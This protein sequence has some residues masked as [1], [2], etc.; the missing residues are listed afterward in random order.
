MERTTTKKIF[1]TIIALLLS[2][3]LLFSCKDN[4]SQVVG[5]EETGNNDNTQLLT[6]AIS[7]QVTN[8]LTGS[9]LEDVSVLL[10]TDTDVQELT[11]DTQGK[12]STEIQLSANINII[13]V[14]SKTG[15]ITDSTSAYVI[16]GKDK[17]VQRLELIPNNTG[18]VPS[19]DPVSIFMQ[20]QSSE[21]IGVKESGSEETARIIFIVQDSAGTPIDL[22]HTVDV[23]FKF[24]AQPGGGEE[25]SPTSVKTNN[26]GE[27]IVNLTAGTKAGTVQ[28]IAEIQLA[29]KKITS[30]P[31]GISIHG[32]LPDDTHFSIAPAVVNF[33][34][35][36]R[37]GLIDIIT[38]YVGD[39]YAN[40]VRPNT[41]VYFTSTGGIID[42]STQTDELGIGSVNLISS[43]PQPVHPIFGAGFA[44]ITA[45]TAD[46]NSNTIT[47]QIVVL[48]SGLPTI[49]VSPNSINIPNLGSQSFSY[50][51]QDQNGNPL[52][53]GTAITVNV[54]G[55]NVKLT[56][57]KSIQLPDTQSKTWT[58][59]GFSVTDTDSTTAVRTVSITISSN[60]SNGK[61]EITIYGTAH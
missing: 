54:D 52:T 18:T 12:Y 40:P 17:S 35:Y 31:V 58:Q 21:F 7:G 55:D 30:L 10:F 43:A 5:G 25:L 37:Y 45:S 24:G 23:N 19:G 46:E 49:N 57:Q 39:K 4:S 33:A 60:G 3:F 16:A 50:S 9:P 20:D 15:F 48:F 34:G 53:G 59:F 41:A 26:K 56:G 11:T 47:D 42:G 13:L 2:S 27:A 28:I 14:V 38:A 36:N 32:G 51:V 8:S 29:N 44:T 6:S 1:T 61:D 22:D